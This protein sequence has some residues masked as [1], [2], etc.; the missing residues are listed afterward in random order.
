MVKSLRAWIVDDCHRLI[1]PLWR[2]LNSSLNFVRGPWLGPVAGIERRPRRAPRRNRGRREIQGRYPQILSG[3][4]PSG[5]ALCLSDLAAP[6]LQFE[7][8]LLRSRELLLGRGERRRRGVERG[9][10]AR[11][12]RRV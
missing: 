1:L 7:P 6:Q 3:P 9:A 2:L 10:I 12:K 5:R 11:I 8:A 4:K